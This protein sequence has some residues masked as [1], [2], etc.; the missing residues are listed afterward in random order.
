MRSRSSI[1]RQYSA[2]MEDEIIIQPNDEEAWLSTSQN[3]GL[4]QVHESGSTSTIHC[5]ST[6]GIAGQL[7][8][9][10]IKTSAAFAAAIAA[11]AA[12]ADE[13]KVGSAGNARPP[14][15]APAA[16]RARVAGPNGGG[17]EGTA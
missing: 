15:V 13:E 10:L 5:R 11:P 8:E 2:G 16:S 6:S 14:V 1:I 9:E 3:L 12:A 17:A 4:I 7:M